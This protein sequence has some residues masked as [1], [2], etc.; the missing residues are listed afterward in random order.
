MELILNIA[1][2]VRRWIKALSGLDYFILPRPQISIQAERFGS[3]YGGWYIVS[4][5]INDKS[6]VYSFG[7]GEDASFDIELVNRFYL[8]VH[9]FDPTPKSIDW[10]K[11]QKLSSNFIMHE[12]GIADFDGK[13]RF[14][15]P[16]NPAH[17]SHSILYRSSTKSKSLN[18]PVKKL[19]SIMNELGHTTIDILKMDIEGAEYQVIKD[20]IESNIKPVQ[21]LVEFHH[22]FP[23]VGIKRTKE[24]I[25]LL[26]NY[27]FLLYYISKNGEQF[28]FLKKL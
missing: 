21:I 25:K 24:A 4:K 1:R 19:S 10:V 17:I 20:L 5:D 8:L 16:E 18:V 3:V 27:G 22:R 7:V 15:P 12:Y 13:V 23:N 6:I 2:L 14:F 26:N 28:N 9:A 11:M